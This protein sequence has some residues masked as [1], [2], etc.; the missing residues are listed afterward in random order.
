M[1]I[2]GFRARAG[3]GC[4]YRIVVWIVQWAEQREVIQVMVGLLLQSRDRDCSR[5]G[6]QQSYT[7]LISAFIKLSGKIS[8]E[9]LS[10]PK[11]F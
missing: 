1:V 9:S 2:K 3:H 5:R 7:C 11:H 10:D 6:H 8:V 4:D